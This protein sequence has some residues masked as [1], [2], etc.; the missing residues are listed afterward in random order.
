MAASTVKKSFVRVKLLEVSCGQLQVNT[1]YAAVSVLDAEE[2]NGQSK[3]VQKKPTFYP[4]WGQCF[5]SHVGRKRQLAL[6]IY[7][8]P[9]MFIAEV[10]V[11]IES[12][13][14]QCRGK[15][16]QITRISVSCALCV[17]CVCQYACSLHVCVS[18]ICVLYLTTSRLA[19]ACCVYYRL[20]LLV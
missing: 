16:N 14:E 13:S 17:V 11:E 2:Q 10:I 15:P 19:V 9:E 4:D 1:P 12:L 18:C 8:E 6:T 5:D 7:D 20:L 3:M